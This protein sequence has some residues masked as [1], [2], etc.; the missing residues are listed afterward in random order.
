MHHDV[1][2][3]FANFYNLVSRPATPIG[4]Y[5]QAVVMLTPNGD[6]ACKVEWHTE[7]PS[8]KVLFTFTG[9]H[10]DVWRTTQ[11]GVMSL[12]AY[13]VERGA[14][15]TRI[16]FAVDVL[17]DNR[18]SVESLVAR[19][20]RTV[21]LRGRSHSVIAS[22]N[23]KGKI[24]TTLYIGSRSSEKFFR[25]YN[26]AAEQGIER[27]WVRIELEAKGDYANA[28]GKAMLT[29]GWDMAVSEMRNSIVCTEGWYVDALESPD[30]DKVVVD[31]TAGHTIQWQ[32][33]ALLSMVKSALS[34]N[35]FFRQQVRLALAELDNSE[36]PF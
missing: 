16:D 12:F 35:V 15:F 34:D 17:D 8:Q 11:V 4:Y 10:L 25:I 32:N 23:G 29:N 21:D 20:G 19:I 27:D 5:N 36:L 3:D 18:A 9:R 7:K 24:G 6:E 33:T 31:R 1:V 2:G 28:L 26:K 13:A 14:K 22:D 30:F